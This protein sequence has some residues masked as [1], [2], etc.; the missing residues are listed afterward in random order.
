MTN[1]Q[2]VMTSLAQPYLEGLTEHVL[3]YQQCTACSRAQ[4]FAHDA[5]QFCGAEALV[6]NTST[7]RGHVHAVT[8]VGRAP[9]D[10]FR[11]LAPYTLVVVTL[12]DGARLMGHATPGVQIGDAV[13]ATFFKHLD[14]TL[15]RFEP[16]G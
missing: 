1:N 6:W 14:Q 3:R 13:T 4:T 16:L 5:C 7:G 9:S 2:S 12:E 15:V 10:A 11:S 8:V